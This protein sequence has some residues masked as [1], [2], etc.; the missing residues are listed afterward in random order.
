ME[1]SIDPMNPAEVLACAGL[2]HLA[3]RRDR[4][5]RT[6]FVA[7]D[8]GEVRFAVP[9]LAELSEPLEL[10]AME[11]DAVR[12]GGVVLDWWCPWGLN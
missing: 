12:L 7:G 8:G 9:E 3:W 5:A 2:A 1:W 10:E 4:N 6:G 11:G